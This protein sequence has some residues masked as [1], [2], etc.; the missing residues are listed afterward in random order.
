MC[1]AGLADQKDVKR[2]KENYRK[3]FCIATL[4]NGG[5]GLDLFGRACCWIRWEHFGIR[6][7]RRVGATRVEGKKRPRAKVT[8]PGDGSHESPSHPGR[9]AGRVGRALE[10]LHES[11]DRNPSIT[12][13]VLPRAASRLPSGHDAPPRPAHSLLHRPDPR[14]ARPRRRPSR[15]GLHLS[16]P[17][18]SRG[19]RRARRDRRRLRRPELR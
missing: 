8:L 3:R 6:A 2:S 7:N 10:Q 11:P 1:I 19:A 4:K 13:V 17:G 14:L 12:I 16:H 18:G 15:V 9:L 5:G